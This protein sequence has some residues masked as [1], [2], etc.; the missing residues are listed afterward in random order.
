VVYHMVRQTCGKSMQ[1]ELAYMQNRLTNSQ[2]YLVVGLVRLVGLGLLL[3][4]TIKV[5][6]VS[7]MVSARFSVH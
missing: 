1:Q 4:V 2:W 6:R 3:T 5:S 7:A